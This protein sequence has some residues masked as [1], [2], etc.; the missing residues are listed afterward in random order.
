MS[1]NTGTPSSAST[2]R[3][4]MSIWK[5]RG[6]CLAW[7]GSKSTHR[8]MS[9]PPFCNSAGRPRRACRRSAHRPRRQSSRLCRADAAPRRGGRPP[10]TTIAASS[11]DWHVDWH[12][13]HGLPVLCLVH[14]FAGNRHTWAELLPELVD[15]FPSLAG[16]SAG[17]RPDAAA[18][19]GRSES[20][21]AGHRAWPAH[22]Q[23][24]RR[25]GHALR[26]QH[27]RTCGAAHR[28]L[29]SRICDGAGIDRRVA[30]H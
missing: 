22:P 20:R 25:S 24:R 23:R 14:G 7:H 19:R 29:R 28:A 18:A 6:T 21:T 10:M 2:P 13:P 12:G 4:R 30:R 1:T 9:P 3:R 16:G 5:R 8:G 11:I 27:G 17:P 15:A 26:L